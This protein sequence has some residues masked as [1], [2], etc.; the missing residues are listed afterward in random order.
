MRLLI[1]AG[2]TGGGVYPALAVLQTLEIEKKDVLWIGSENPMEA[3]ILSKQDINFKP[4]P[5]AGVHGVGIANLPGNISKIYQGYV[6]ARKTI[7]EFKPNVIFYTGGFI[8]FP[9]SLASRHIS[10]VAFVPDIEPGTA[11]KYLIPR[12]DI[13]TV[14]TDE[15]ISYLPKNKKVEVTGYPI[16]PAFLK[17]TS[18]KGKKVLGLHNHK[19]VLLVFGGSKGAQSINQAIQAILPKLLAE[20]QIIHI[21]GEDNWNA[22]KE[23]IANL[24][25]SIA[26][27]YHAFPFLHDEMGAALAS[28][29]L[30]VCRSGAST[31]GELPFF[32]LPAILVP[33]PHAWR[34]QYTNAE[35][36]VKH[37]GALLMKDQDM[38]DKLLDI[39][40]SLLHNPTRLTRMADCMHQLA[41]PDAAQK[42]GKIIISA[43]KQGGKSTWS[44]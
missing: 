15:S 43:S 40:I 27:D 3:R 6:R 42:I 12:C 20:S 16:R 35:Y 26:K 11:L 44:V 4:I 2:M 41:C 5:A 10:S 25:K 32:G 23:T 1:C 39:I 13:I 8:S 38:P 9:V 31:L 7:R 29:D 18:A 21:I 37:G 22:S 36:L 19:P 28:A 30:V 34:Y 14:A 24:N 33:Y 17:W